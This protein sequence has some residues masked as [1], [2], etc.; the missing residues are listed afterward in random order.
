M[1]IERGEYPTAEVFGFGTG[2][3]NVG[4]DLEGAT[5]EIGFT[6]DVL[7]GLVVLKTLGNVLELVGRYAGIAPHQEVGERQS[8]THLIDHAGNGFCLAFTIDFRQ[9]VP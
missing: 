1:T 8:V 5:T 4:V 3:E 9:S 6:E 7:H 2:D